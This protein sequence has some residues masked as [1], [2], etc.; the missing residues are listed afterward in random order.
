MATVTLDAATN[1]YDHRVNLYFYSAGVEVRYIWKSWRTRPSAWYLFI[2]YSSLCVRIMSLVTFEVGSFGSKLSHTLDT[3]KSLLS[4][5]QELFVACTLL[6]RVL[7][8]YAFNKKVVFS[9]VMLSILGLSLSIVRTSRFSSSAFSSSAIQ[10]KQN[11]SRV[12][13]K[14][15]TGSL[16]HVLFGD[17][18][19]AGSLAG[20][21]VSSGIIGA[22]N[23]QYSIRPHSGWIRY[24]LTVDLNFGF[25]DRPVAFKECSYLIV[26]RAP[27]IEEEKH[28]A[29]E[30]LRLPA[31]SVRAPTRRVHAGAPRRRALGAAA[32][33]A[34]SAAGEFD[35]VNFRLVQRPVGGD[36]GVTVVR[37]ECID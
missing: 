13:G 30:H 2:R 24:F 4:V 10:V 29:V 18:I 20:F 36:G 5:I 17:V 25:R 6:L 15:S 11:R 37:G 31:S 7:A 9:L 12:I 34:A 23:E 1:A 3:T 26:P 27:D 16:W 33:S 21:T 14:F 32:C 28:E 35:V 19:T 22:G 8:M